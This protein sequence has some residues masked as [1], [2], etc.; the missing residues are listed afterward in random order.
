MLC[1]SNVNSDLNVELYVIKKNFSRLI[2]NIFIPIA[3]FFGSWFCWGGGGGGA[4]G[5]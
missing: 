5:E 4:H 2:N 1:V 3:C